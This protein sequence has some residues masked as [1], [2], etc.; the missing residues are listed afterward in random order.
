[1]SIYNIGIFVGSLRKEAFSR[2]LANAVSAIMPEDFKPAIIEIDRLEMFNE[3]LDV[4]GKE[5][6][7]WKNFRAKVRAL[8]AVLFITPEY[9]RSVTPALK[10]ALDVASR[11]WGQSVWGGKPGAVIS[12][13]PGKLGAFGANH[14]LRQ[15]LTFLNV[16]MMQQPE[17]YLSEAGD[18]FDEKGC[19][20]NPH[21]KD[22]LKTFVEA[23]TAWVK[24]LIK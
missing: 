3:D 19:V 2:K 15:S 7:C 22:F 23:Y 6:E 16:P 13:T 5:P 1:M 11:P 18:I 21:T 14:H 17:A 10:N 12:I 20:C 24:K 8:D 4:E 9:N